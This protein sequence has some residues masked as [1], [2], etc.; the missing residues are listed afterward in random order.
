MMHAI[1]KTG[2]EP[3]SYPEEWWNFT[4]PLSHSDLF[5]PIRDVDLSPEMRIMART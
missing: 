3:L 5:N 2:C 1:A 4:F